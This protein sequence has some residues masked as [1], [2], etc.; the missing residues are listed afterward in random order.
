[1]EFR[2]DTL[3]QI[4]A[5][6]FDDVID[7]RRP[8]EFADDHLPSAVNLPL[9]DDRERADVAAHDHYRPIDQRFAYIIR[10]YGETISDTDAVHQALLIPLQGKKRVAGWADLAD[11]GEHGELMQ[12]HYDRRAQARRAARVA[13]IVADKLDAAGLNSAADKL[14]RALEGL[15]KR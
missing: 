7:V 5:H 9:L 12:H 15:Q 1:M 14:M 13:T 4:F 10:A 6:D 11:A 8:T 2:A 3:D